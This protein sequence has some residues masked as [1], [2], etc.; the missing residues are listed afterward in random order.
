MS[1]TFFARFQALHVAGML[2]LALLLLF[3][4]DPVHSAQPDP[5]ARHAVTLALGKEGDIYRASAKG[6][7][8]SKN[9]GK[10]WSPITLPSAIQGMPISG[11]ALAA[12]DR[13]A[14]YLAGPEFGVLQSRDAGKSWTNISQTLP[15]KKVAALTAHAV[16]SETVYAYV[17]EK[18]IFRSQDAGASW[19]LVDRGPRTAIRNVV[20][21]DMPGS[22]ETGWLFAAT[23]NGVRRSMDCFCGWHIAGDIDSQV[24]DVVYDPDQPRRVYAA[25]ENGV[26]VSADG[27]EAWSALS[28]P[29]ATVTAL[30]AGPS[31]L[32]YAAGEESLYRSLD[33]GA[34]WEQIHGE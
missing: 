6:L 24:Y 29:D 9:G 15:G 13:N 7:Q 34:K 25:A 33:H 23:G 31:G 27:G 17:E 10:S 20:H 16:Q 8:L 19:R 11:L 30:A 32:L 14:L 1:T 5:D 4:P 2:G 3:A 21:T 26:F 18:G 22:M 12:N 28:L